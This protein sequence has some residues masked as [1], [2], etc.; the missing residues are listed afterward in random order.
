MTTASLQ[1]QL[2]EQK[3]ENLS[4]QQQRDGIRL[5]LEQLNQVMDTMGCKD[6]VYE[7]LERIMQRFNRMDEGE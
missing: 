7:E 4:V 6:K 5:Q 2:N 1:E 3:I